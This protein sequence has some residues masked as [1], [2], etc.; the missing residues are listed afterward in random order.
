MR[1]YNMGT[2]LRQGGYVIGLLFGTAAWAQDAPVD[3]PA[4]AIVR[5]L[6]TTTFYD[7][8]LRR[9]FTMTFTM[10]SVTIFTTI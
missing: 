6:F 7:D 1:G 9:F 2:M 4:E 3:A 10:I 8:I 5:R